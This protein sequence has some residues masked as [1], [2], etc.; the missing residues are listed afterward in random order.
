MDIVRLVLIGGCVIACV[1]YVIAA[2]CLCK[3]LAMSN[4]DNDPKVGE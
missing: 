2:V 4:D 1:V 3:F